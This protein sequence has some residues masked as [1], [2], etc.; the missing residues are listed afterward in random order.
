MRLVEIDTDGLCEVILC[1][2]HSR[3]HEVSDIEFRVLTVCCA[4]V[5]DERIDNSLSKPSELVIKPSVVVFSVELRPPYGL[6]LSSSLMRNFTFARYTGL[7][8]RRYA[9]ATPRHST[10]DSRNHC[11]LRMNVAKWWQN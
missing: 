5:A 9:A 3:L 10:T 2:G 6:F 1:C 8:Y 7:V 4:K 11:Q